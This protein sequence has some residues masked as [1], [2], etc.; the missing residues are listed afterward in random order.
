[1]ENEYSEQ[2]TDP[3]LRCFFFQDF[4]YRC[5]PIETGAILSSTQP[6]HIHCAR[7]RVRVCVCGG[8]Q[9]WGWHAQI[10]PELSRSDENYH[11]NCGMRLG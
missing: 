6:C 5:R 1:M 10:S 3:L 4:T 2:Q 8:E 7:V 11:A 9:G